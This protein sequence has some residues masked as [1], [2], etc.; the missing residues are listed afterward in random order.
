L[1]K[2]YTFLL[3]LENIYKWQNYLVLNCFFK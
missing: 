2:E 1:A 3:D